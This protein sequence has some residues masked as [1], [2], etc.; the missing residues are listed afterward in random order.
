V[1]RRISAALLRFAALGG[2]LIVPALAAAQLKCTNDTDKEIRKV[3]FTGN[4]HFTA[5]DLADHVV[6]TPTDFTRRF[7]PGIGTKR[8]LQPGVLAADI[9]RL[10]SF[11][12]DQGFPDARVDTIT[13]TDGKWVDIRFRVQEGE[14]VL[15]DSVAITGIDTLVLGGGLSNALNSK[16]GA[17]FS[18]ALRQA[19]IDTLEAR[20][21]NS[22][23]PL[24]KVD[25]GPVVP[26]D[27][28]VVV[29]LNVRPGPKARIGKIT[30]TS[31]GP[32]GR[33]SALNP[34]VPSDIL[35]FKEGDVYRER[36]L[37]ESE[38]Q[39]Y[40]VGNFL[41]AAVI[42]DMSH[43]LKDSLVDVNVT[44]LEDLMKQF[45]INPGYGTLDCLRARA[46]YTD[47][48]FLH[49]L[50]RIELS[51][52]ASKLGWARPWPVIHD[53]CNFQPFHLR[54]DQVSSSKINYNT[55]AKLTRPTTLHGGLLP[56][57]SAY[58][59]QRG[60]FNAYLRTTKIG[61]AAT[62]SKSFPRGLVAQT[63][64]N[65]EYGHTFADFAVLCFLFRACDETTRGQ[66][67]GADKRLAIF[68]LSGSR[69]MRN[70]P[71]STTAGTVVGLDLRTAS[72]L[73]GSDRNLSFNKGVMDAGWYHR[74]IGSGVI[75]VR[76]RG[77]LIGGGAGTVGGA[78][79]PPPQERLY[80]GGATSI[81]GFGQNELGPQ[82]FVVNDTT[83][84][85]SD[86]TT[87]GLQAALQNLRGK[88]VIPTGG[89]TMYVANLEYRIR[90]PFLPSLQTILFADAGR[91]WSRE[92][93][94]EAGQGVKL[95]PGIAVRYFSPIGPIQVN[96][97][98][99]QY[100]RPDGPVFFDGGVSATTGQAP[101]QCLSGVD[102][103]NVCLPANAWRPPNTL[104]K[105]LTLSIAFPP[106]F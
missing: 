76:V 95:T 1:N 38:R 19:D 25:A 32:E 90:G 97:G 86:S 73:I 75:A 98:Y 78:R 104:F 13:T 18:N 46:A 66:L 24:G 101:L 31:S 16:K 77:G 80:A 4:G 63:S 6:S 35:R 53:I 49:G 11:Y 44:V 61:G 84:L 71:D 85:G 2:L 69:D 102:A 33:P 30:V 91:V 83:G 106:D 57:L 17:R 22:G 99:N 39:F 79:L 100:P 5:A 81:R 74:A 72:Q 41:S 9:L 40:R 21:R 103:K 23:F 70:N 29:T 56:S 54:D 87:S 94:N 67:L 36:A 59:E 47:K 64:Y 82:I 68:G 62:L 55:S 27:H 58:S 26:A 8:C 51:A 10:R 60:A 65:L 37:Y 93:S 14:P 3:S 42:P 48:A 15:I 12:N 52:Q 45:E 92:L 43:V 88:R 28:H 96:V 105:R 34:L 50:N 20:M 89:N 7:L